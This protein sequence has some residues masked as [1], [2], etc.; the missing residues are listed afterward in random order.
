[1]KT[2]ILHQYKSRRNCAQLVQTDDGIFVRKCY[3]EREAY[4]REL[5]IYRR[6]QDSSLP[7]AEVIQAGDLTILTTHL[8]G[9]DLVN[10]LD[11]QE[12]SGI[13]DWI[14]WEKLVKWL[15]DFYYLTGFV[16]TDV[17]L[18]NFLYDEDTQT[19]YGVD[20]EECMEGGLFSAVSR[21]AAY[22]RTYAPENTP[23][24][25][26]IAQ[27][28]LRRFSGHLNIELQVLLLETEKQEALLLM[29]RM[30]RT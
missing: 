19:V 25:Q 14:V 30:G 28:V 16:M 20:F 5:L 24:K 21:L 9:T 6:L 10:I 26:A 7:R 8:P 4:L 13:I 17:N 18:R 3:Q 23:L 12:R 29:R 2:Q 15:A 11:S 1:M 27:Y 22:I